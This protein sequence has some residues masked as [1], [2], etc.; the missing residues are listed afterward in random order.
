MRDWA[1]RVR[2]G[3]VEADSSSKDEGVS[4]RSMEV[5]SGDFATEEEG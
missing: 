4:A 3:V 1:E 5:G 2:M